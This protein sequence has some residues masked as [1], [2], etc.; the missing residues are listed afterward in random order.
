MYIKSIFVYLSLFFV[1]FLKADTYLYEN[2][3]FNKNFCALLQLLDID[4]NGSFKEVL[5]QTQMQW[6]QK[7]KERWEFLSL[8]EEKK[9]QLTPLLKS[10]NCIQPIYAENTFY[11]KAVLHGST[12]SS[13][14]KRLHFLIEEYKRG[15]LF[16]QIV[17]LTGKRTLQKD[18]E[19]IFC[20][21]D[22]T[23]PYLSFRKDW[24][25]RDKMP[26]TEDEM[27]EY[28]FDQA[29]MPHEFKKIPRLI[30]SSPN[31]I[32]ENQKILRATTEDTIRLWKKLHHPQGTILAISEQP[33]V[34][35]Q[36]MILKYF[37]PDHVCETIGP[38]ARSH[39][40]MSIYLDTLTK[41]LFWIEKGIL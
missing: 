9:E 14:R 12:L 23:N 33:F 26:S 32:G 10:L 30:I 31:S 6:L 41:T 36:H 40:P 15:V 39:L 1:F 19:N 11:D 7:G 29:D 3:Q 2:N 27:I 28:V 20:L 5:N 16:N 37:F 18:T 17:I 25:A 35:Y 4:P 24:V 22:E 13:F 34:I 8:Y 21:N 38:Q